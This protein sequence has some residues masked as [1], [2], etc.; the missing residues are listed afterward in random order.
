MPGS[1]LDPQSY[2]N[3]A[4]EALEDAY[5]ESF[6]TPAGSLILKAIEAIKRLKQ[7]MKTRRN[8]GVAADYDPYEVNEFNSA[9]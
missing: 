3:V 7:E 4:L 6:D 5:E 1:F 9:I 2:A 8:S